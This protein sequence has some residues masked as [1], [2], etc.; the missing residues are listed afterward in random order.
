MVNIDATFHQATSTVTYLVWD[1]TSL[2]AAIIDP[3]LDYDQNTGTLTTQSIDKILAK[4]DQQK[5]FLKWTLE[6]H[7]HADHLSAADYIKSKKPAKSGIG[8]NIGGVQKSFK[9]MFNADDVSTD[10]RAFDM[11]FAD[12]DEIK[13]G[14]TIVRILHTPGHTLACVSYLIDDAVFV[15]DTVFMP[16]YGSA[17]TDF[18]GGD[19]ATLYRSVMR[20]YQLPEQT[21]VFV[22]HDYPPKDGRGPVWETTIAEQRAHNIHINDSVSE[23]DFVAMR[24]ARD[25]TLSAPKLI[26]PALQINIRAGALPPKDTNGHHY[27]KIPVNLFPA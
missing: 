8:W 9:N 5:L 14:D 16:D 7:P 3:V 21:R 20:L 4:A 10:G 6:T 27:L 25:A 26:L 11:L 15:G 23:T 13:L 17:R 18:P 24:N 1:P 12:G 22:G 2:E 19:A